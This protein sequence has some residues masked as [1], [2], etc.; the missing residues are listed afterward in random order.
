MI[1]RI[2]SFILILFSL[3]Q[4]SKAKEIKVGIFLD[5]KEIEISSK[6][7]INILRNKKS[8]YV[9]KPNENVKIWIGKGKNVS[10]KSYDE[11]LWYLQ[12][13]AFKNQLSIE[14]CIEEIKK[15]TDEETIVEQSKKS[16]LK[17]VK[18]GPFVKLSNATSVKDVLKMNGFPDVFVCT[19]EKN[20]NSGEGIY[21]IT[22]NYNKYFLTKSEITLLSKSPIAVNNTYYRGAIEIKRYGSK[23]NVINKLPISDYLRGVVPAEMSPSLYPSLDA[24]KAQA[25]AART[26]TFYNLNQFKNMDFDI[27]AT[28]SCQVYKGVSVE[29]EMSDR[30]VLET[31]GEIITYDGKPINSLFTAYCGGHTEDVENVFSGNPVPYLKGVLCEGE[32][33]EWEKIVV[34]SKY[35]LET[36]VSAYDSNPSLA[37]SLLYAKGI[38]KEQDL[39]K[40]NSKINSENS[41]PILASL[42]E[43]LGISTNKEKAEIKNLNDVIN[44]LSVSIFKTDDPSSLFDGELVNQKVDGLDGRVIDVACICYS[45]LNKFYGFENYDLNHKI[46]KENDLEEI[47]STSFLFLKQGKTVISVPSVSLR[48]GDRIRIMR[49][50][51]RIN[52]LVVLTPESQL[53]VN[54]SF[55]SSYNWYSYLNSDNLQ[56]QVR[57][58]GD[59]GIIRDIKILKTSSTGRITEIMVIGTTTSKK[60]TGLRVRWVLGVKENKFQLFKMLDTFGNLKGVYL[61][62]TAWGHGVGMCQIGAFGLASKGY[63]YKEILKHYYQGVEIEKREF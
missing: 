37:V 59:F 21:L 60:F 31:K 30:A 62:G 43:Y 36:L 1:I 63:S 6:E 15:L 53:G 58:Y 28:Q 55:L 56:K 16:K 20:D 48:V 50:G 23:I 45:I 49:F 8:I 7:S 52:A 24:I 57:K 33:G 18:I 42:M 38:I 11:N 22:K 26:Y 19:S 46:L 9:I 27:C 13:G 34:K 41:F 32:K 40:L 54:D 47:D 5:E 17:I 61:S 3:S 12:A 4:Y 14:K 51:E 44:F 39:L 2:V 25:V 10:E 29:Q 35:C